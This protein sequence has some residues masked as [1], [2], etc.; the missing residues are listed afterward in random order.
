MKVVERPGFIVVFTPFDWGWY[1]IHVDHLTDPN[2]RVGKL[3]P[4][5][6]HVDLK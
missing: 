1:H 3:G 6:Y 4:V 2:Y 5:T